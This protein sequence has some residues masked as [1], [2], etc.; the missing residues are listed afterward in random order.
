MK[1][2]PW[3][4]FVVQKSMLVRPDRL[5]A[6]PEVGECLPRQNGKGG[7]LEIFS[8]GRLFVLESELSLH[9]AHLFKTSIEA[10]LRL[11]R[12]IQNCPQL[13]RRVAR[14]AN[15]RGDE[16]IILKNGC[17]IQYVARSGGSGRGLTGNCVILDEAMYLP[18][19][20]M[21]ALVPTISAKEYGQIIYAG[22][23]VD[24][25]TMADG[26]TF[27]RVRK[28]GIEGSSERLAYFEWSLP[29]DSPS[30]IPDDV[31]NDPESAR[32]TNP[33]YNLRIMPDT[34][35][36]ELEMLGPWSYAVERLNVGDWPAVD[37]EDQV[38][39]VE[40]WN[41]ALDPA[42][43]P[44]DPV[45][46]S[47]DVSP[48]RRRAAISVAGKRSD[49]L[50]HIEV[51]DSRAGTAWAVERL[52]ELTGRHS[53]TAVV[54][55]GV[56]QAKSLIP[57]L[58]AVGVEVVVM[59][60]DDHAQA[61]GFIFDAVENGTVKHRGQAALNSAV[62]GAAQRPL[63]DRWAWSRKTSGADITPLV[64]CTLA[65]WGSATLSAGEILVAF[66]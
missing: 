37:G 25:T 50:F 36:G 32:V 35:S 2:D 3:Q 21:A 28:R 47:F 46:F 54:V 56:G 38:F 65:L 57:D 39:P 16:G 4:Q 59:N 1:P 48:D 58:E 9:S 22:S 14:Y 6:S 11:K 24:Q 15:A 64:A 40:K 61:C 13:D 66:A 33:A 30:E 44:L 52:K 62:R 12:L 42:S 10:Y 17:R 53:S 43:A 7:T 5:L 8:L 49:E 20:V 63:N 23:A 29:Y 26:Q 27:A 41:Q 19:Q 34:V 31:L 51:L 45:C 18:A 60:S 55:D